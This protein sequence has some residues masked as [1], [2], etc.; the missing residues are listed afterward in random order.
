MDRLLPPNMP[1]DLPDD[2]TQAVEHRILM[3]AL[4]D[5][6]VCAR[7][8]W[9]MPDAE[10]AQ[11]NAIAACKRVGVNYMRMLE[12]Y[13]K[14]TGCSWDLARRQIAEWLRQ[15]ADNEFLVASE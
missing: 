9:Y 7:I 8:A 6:H 13:W 11:D 2:P 1:E 5:A 12:D 15:E 14:N 4:E 10:G 3:E